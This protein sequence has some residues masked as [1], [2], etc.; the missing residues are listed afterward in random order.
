M[1]SQDF[2]QEKTLFR[3]FYEND[4]RNLESSVD[5][6][7]TLIRSLVQ[8]EETIQISK[9]EGRVK[10]K[11]ECIKKF[12]RKYLQKVESENI[13]YEIKDFISDLVGLRIVCLY[14]DQVEKINK[15]ESTEDSFGYK[16]LHM[17]LKLSPSRQA[18]P[19]YSAHKEIQF[20]LQIRTTI[21]DSW[22][23]LDHKIKYKKSIPK[24]LK[25]RINTLA[26][27][28]ELADHEFLAIKQETIKAIA[29]AELPSEDE[30][31]EESAKAFDSLIDEKTTTQRGSLLNAFSLLKIA[32][33][34]FKDFD[35][36]A[37]N[38]DG[39][40]KEIIYKQPLIT[41]GKFNFYMRNTISHVKSYKK[42]FESLDSSNKFNPYTQVRHCL[43]LADKEIFSEIISSTS[44]ENFEKWLS[45]NPLVK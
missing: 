44:K 4:R 7:T 21:Q 2:E 17:D 26:A 15:I 23:V 11:E 32:Q 14:E 16:G 10:E 13:N 40:T 20:E 9:V 43:Y 3:S 41:K 37:H 24:N 1:A 45:E 28:F 36:E 34:F 29:E 42:Y 31:I 35:F 18:L 27:L 12:Q 39:L 22:S 25:R 19:E 5:I 8:N 33:H 38:V 30:I 6:F